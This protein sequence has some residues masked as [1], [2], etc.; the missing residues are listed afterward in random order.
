[1]AVNN[2]FISFDLTQFVREATRYGKD[3][4]TLIDYFCTNFDKEN[5]LCKVNSV[6]FSDHESILVN[7]HLNTTKTKKY[8]FGRIFSKKNYKKFKTECDRTNWVISSYNLDPL[9]MIHQM[10]SKNFEKAFPIIKIKD[11]KK[12]PWITTGIKTSARNMRSLLV[13]RKYTTNEGFISYVNKYKKIYKKTLRLAKDRYYNS[14]I[15]NSSNSVKENWAI[16]NELRGKTNSFKASYNVSPDQFNEFFSTIADELTSKLTVKHDPLKYIEDVNITDACHLYSTN[17]MELKENIAAIKNKNAAGY[18]GISIKIFYN[19]PDSTLYALVD[20]IN[21]SFINGTFPACLK[22]AIVVPQHKGGSLEDPSNFRPI[23]LLPTLSKIIEGLVKSRMVDF[24]TKHQILATCQFGFQASKNTQDAM[25]SFL[26]YAYSNL[27]QGEMLASVFCDFSKAFDCVRHD[28][29]LKKLFIYGLRNATWHWFRSY[30]SDRIQIIRVSDKFSKFSEIKHGVPQGSVLG[31]I[32]FLIYIND[33]TKIS[34]SGKFT[35]FADDTTLLWHGRDTDTLKH[36]VSHDLH[37]IKNWCD[38][39]FLSLNTNK[40][41]ILTFK[42]AY[43]QLRLGEQLIINTPCSRFLGLYIDNQLKFD[44]HVAIL[45]KKLASGC[46]AVRV[47]AKELG[48]LSARNVYF[49][50]IDTHL[51]YG[52]VFW[53]NCSQYLLNSVFILQKRAIRFLAKSDYR[54]HCKPLFIKYKILTLTSLF[55]LETVCMIH[56]QILNLPTQSRHYNTRQNNNLLLPIP[57]SSLIKNSI[58]YESPKIFNHLPDALKSI[59]SPSLF[60]N[61]IKNILI[62]K[63]YYNLLEFYNDEF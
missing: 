32:L 18:D 62:G 2:L 42:F 57:H 45:N 48:S 41:N 61:T 37:V 60:R 24:L 11:K 6:D 29:L 13:I 16:I 3:S 43:D 54:D 8:R 46:F 58:I 51:R 44:E 59:R 10:I 4:A 9:S 31:P 35:L 5:V 14:R 56:K 47:I 40:T 36:T 34:I 20:A 38:S 49:S 39:N 33:L 21:L 55:I 7:I 19:L 27:N 17:I 25:F 26:E 1:M 63:P 53:G 12:K 23:S 15:Q 28:I 50:L 52:I 30:L 22:T